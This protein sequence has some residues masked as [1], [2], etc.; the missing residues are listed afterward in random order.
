MTDCD[1]LLA[2]ILESPDGDTVRLI[3]ADAL[4]EAAGHATD[5]GEFVRSQIQL[6][7]MPGDIERD[8][9]R[10][11][12]R[13]RLRHLIDQKAPA[14]IMPGLHDY[15]WSGDEIEPVVT[16]YTH[17]GG[18]LVEQFRYLVTRGFASAITATATD[19]IIHGD[20]ITSRHPIESVTLTTYPE[21]VSDGDV[22]GL[23]DDPRG[24]LYPL[25]E[26]ITYAHRIATLAEALLK[27]RWK[28]V[29]AWKLPNDIIAHRDAIE[30]YARRDG[31]IPPGYEVVR[32]NYFAGDSHHQVIAHHCEDFP[33]LQWSQPISPDTATFSHIEMR[34]SGRY[35]VGDMAYP[36]RIGRCDRCR[37]S[38][39]AISTGER[40]TV[41]A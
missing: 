14:A 33:M 25:S 39:V 16:T 22:C 30:G 2:A 23:R 37:R 26:V 28:R 41:P 21:T 5:R 4:D 8:D 19:F 27:L 36:V 32:T 35:L 3:Y 17:P 9:D 1:A 29:K 15:T 34:S 24:V 13:L 11:W 20:T 12:V 10:E 31:T 7:R 6:L 40:R 18:R 38:F